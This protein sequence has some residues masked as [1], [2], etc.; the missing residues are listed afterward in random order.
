ML[1]RD[2]ALF[3]ILAVGVSLILAHSWIG[4]IYWVCIGLM[5]LHRLSWGPVYDFQFAL[6]VAVLTFLGIL[7]TRDERRWKG[8]IEVYL[9]L[10]FVVWFS[11]TTLFVFNPDRAL[12]ML[13]QTLKV[14]LM[15][16]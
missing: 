7:V 14:E 6:A 3:G 5:S 4:V 2:L 8:G 15:V 11:F 9:L 16:F 12:P 1:F 13:E 10:A